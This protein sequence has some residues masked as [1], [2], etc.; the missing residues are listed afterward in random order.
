MIDYDEYVSKIVE[1]ADT[2]L[3]DKITILTG[4]NAGGK[5]LIR[6]LLKGN[7]AEQLGKEKAF[8]PHASQELRTNSNPE[9]GALSSFSH[10]LEWLAT[11]H[12]TIHTIEKVLKQ[13][14]ADYYIIDEPEI[15][16][17]EELQLGLID[18]LNETIEKLG[19]GVLIITHSRL[20]VA[21]IKSDVF[22]N[23]EGLSKEEWLNRTPEKISIDDFNKFARELHSSIQ[24]RIN[25]N[26]KNKN[27]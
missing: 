10:D 19:K 17:G 2:I 15:G 13:D 11:S 23:L 5:S 7:I 8:V 26:K 9:F 1:F 22:I 16:I 6:K 25:D 14:K 24:D 27:L 4:R 18:Y 12:N 20:T 21:N 3:A